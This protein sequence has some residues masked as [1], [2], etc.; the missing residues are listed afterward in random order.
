VGAG[1]VECIIKV[2]DKGGLWNEAAIEVDDGAWL[3]LDDAVKIPVV[4]IGVVVA[5]YGNVFLAPGRGGIYLLE[6]I[7]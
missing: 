2:V 5:G 4:G 7:V 1:I 6:E 3:A